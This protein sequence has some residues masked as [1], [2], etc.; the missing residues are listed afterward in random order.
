MYLWK[1]AQLVE[2]LRKSSLGEEHF[3]SYYLATTR[4][5]PNSASGGSVFSSPSLLLHLIR[6]STAASREKVKDC[7]TT[8]GHVGHVA[9]TLMKDARRGLNR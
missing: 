7:G 8:T 5:S 2:D 4:A 3:K 6:H 1:T 9:R